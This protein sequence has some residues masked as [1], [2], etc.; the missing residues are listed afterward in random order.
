ML[1]LRLF[2]V[3]NPPKGCALYVPW[4][5]LD[6]KWAL[7]VHSQTLKRLAER[8]GLCPAEIYGNIHKL[9]WRDLSRVYVG[10][11]VD[12]VNR[13]AVGLAALSSTLEDKS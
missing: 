5:K 8:G 2:P 13:L 9:E 7:H 11:A 1:D 10:K 4:D 6:E 3:L 12:L